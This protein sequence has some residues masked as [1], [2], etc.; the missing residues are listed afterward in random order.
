MKRFRFT[1]LAICLVLLYLGWIDVALFLRNPSP[2][3]IS[4]E[5]LE[6]GNVPREWL[7]VTGG[8]QNLLE[9]I[10]TSGSVE[11]DAFLVPLKSS[12]GEESFSVLVETRNPRIL[13]L[14]AT[15]HFQLDSAEAKEVYLNEHAAEFQGLREVTGMVVSGLIASG[16][17]DKLMK[18][19]KE[20]GMQVPPDVLFLSEGKEPGHW[21]GFFYLGVG[22]LGLIKVLM[23]W[24][25]PP[26]AAVEG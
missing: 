12:P 2:A 1:L 13:E 16:N 22:L 9:A 21:R 18:L 15:Y 4:I 6:K 7:R 20:V 19:A 8:H 24:K 5:E 10:S 26:Q 3:A 25:K 14:L 23:L 17:R 11:L